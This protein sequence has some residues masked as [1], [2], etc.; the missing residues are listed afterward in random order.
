MCPYLF[1]QFLCHGRQ[2]HS[3]VVRN[4]DKD[5]RHQMTP[6]NDLLANRVAHFAA[7]SETFLLRVVQR[8][9]QEELTPDFNIF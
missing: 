2:S 3:L 7:K 8:K 5:T 9:L 1:M 4:L 6:L